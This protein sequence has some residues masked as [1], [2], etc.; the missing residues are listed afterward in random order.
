MKELRI[1]T[2]RVRIGGETKEGLQN[3][4]MDVNTIIWD[5]YRMRLHKKQ[6]RK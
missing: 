2:K 3:I 1:K 4:L 6:R 5:I